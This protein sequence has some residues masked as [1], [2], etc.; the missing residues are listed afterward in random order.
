MFIGIMCDVLPGT[1]PGILRQQA[2]TFVDVQ[3]SSRRNVRKEDKRRGA[4]YRYLKVT[5]TQDKF[6][7]DTLEDPPGQRP[8][9][10]RGKSSVWVGEH[11]HHIPARQGAE[12][13]LRVVSVS[14]RHLKAHSPGMEVGQLVPQ[15]AVA[16]E[17]RAEGQ[18]Q[19]SLEKV[20]LGKLWFA[21]VLVFV[22]VRI[23]S[24]DTL[25]SRPVVAGCDAEDLMKPE[26]GGNNQGMING[27]SNLTETRVPPA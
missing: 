7:H 24:A 5:V 23:G 13:R 26:I 9:Y 27:R 4:L 10:R 16:M 21:N 1:A 19:I 18:T 3:H 14:L 12:K 15:V 22:I 6:L 25:L 20:F 17:E 8:N 2:T 11:P